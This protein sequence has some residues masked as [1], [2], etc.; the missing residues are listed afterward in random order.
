MDQALLSPANWKTASP[1]P[2]ERPTSKALVT[3]RLVVVPLV[4]SRVV[5]VVEA[6]VD[7]ALVKMP[8]KN[9]AR[10]EV[11]CEPSACLV[12]GQLKVMEDR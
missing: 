12:Q 5:M 3:A 6:S 4:A 8:P 10:V 1:V 7:E 9:E 2:V 11:A